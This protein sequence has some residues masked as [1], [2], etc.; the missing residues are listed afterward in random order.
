MIAWRISDETA[1]GF[2]ATAI[3]VTGRW[4]AEDNLRIVR[5][6]VNALTD[7]AAS[8]TVITGADVEIAVGKRGS[9]AQGL[10]LFT[11]ICHLTA[12]TAKFQWRERASVNIQWEDMAAGTDGAP[13]GAE[14]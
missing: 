13:A 10:A 9:V 7:S 2:T 11:G 12:I 3:I 1:A 14:T 6:R 4:W 8:L 5:H